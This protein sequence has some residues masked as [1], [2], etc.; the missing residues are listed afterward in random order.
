MKIILAPTDFSPSSINAVLYAAEL[1]NYLHARLVICTVIQPPVPVS[2][3]P[4]PKS[5]IEDLINERKRDLNELV[6]NIRS[7]SHNQ[8]HI[9]YELLTGAVDKKIE[10][11]TGQYKPLVIVMGI[12]QGKSLT[13]ALFGSAAFKILNQARYPLLIIPEFVKWFPIKQIGFA[14]DME[15]TKE[16]IPSDT[17]KQWINL[18]GAKM[19]II[20]VSPDEQAFDSDIAVE[21]QFLQKEFKSYKPEFY[22]LKGSSLAIELQEFIRQHNLG[23]L[24]IVQKKEQGFFKFL[25]NRHSKEI[26]THDQIPILAIPCLSF[27]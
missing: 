6:V 26:I 1:A 8:L 20:H 4:V 27:R 22:Y 16:T 19:D 2:E 13:R 7:R 14:C 15:N 17:I 11:A 12:K 24:I 9:S 23:L 3:I 25:E 21:S 18:F 10:V 5:A